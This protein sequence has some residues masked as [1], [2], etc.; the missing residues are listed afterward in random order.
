MNTKILVVDDEP[1][2]EML[3]RQGFRRKIQ[4]GAYQL[5]F[6]TNGR[7][8]VSAIEAE[9]DFDIVLLDINMPDMNGLTLLNLLPDLLPT[10]RAVMVSAYGDITNIRTAMN[11]GAFD[12]VFKPISFVDL[13]V[14]IEK[15]I[16]HV[17]ELRESAQLKVIDALKTRFF[18]NITHEFRTPLTLILSPV[19][20]MLREYA[21]SPLLRRNLESVERNARQLLRLVNQLLD[22]AKLEAGHLAVHAQPGDLKGLLEQIVLAFT[23]IAEQKELTLSYDTDLVDTYSFDAEK[24]GQISYNLIANA[25]KFTVQGGRV[26]VLLTV[27]DNPVRGVSL[28][29]KDSGIGIAPDKMPYIFNRFYQADPAT[30][31]TD[32]GTGIGLSLVRELTELMGGTVVVESEVGQGTTFIVELPL[33]IITDQTLTPTSKLPV[34]DWM[35][36][37]SFAA[38]L[39]LRQPVAADAALVLVVE[40]NTELREFLV[41]ELSSHY[42]VLS[43]D[44]GKTGWQLA[45]AELPDVVVSDVMMLGLDGYELTHELKTNPATDHIAVML[46][47]AKAAHESRMMGLQQG[48]DD[49]LAKPFHLE[50]LLLRIHNLTVR[51]QHL[52]EFY[53]QQLIRPDSAAQLETVQEKFLYSAY[54]IIDQHLDDST[55]GVEE[56]ASLLAMSRKTLLRKLQAVVQLSP[57][58]LI[59]QYRLQKAA[60]LL[61]AGY[62]VS[63]TAYQVGFENPSYFATAFKEFYQQTPTEFISKP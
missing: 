55:F 34:L 11:R 5:H 32:P 62:R 25:L 17:S 51:Q 57:N 4:E 47:T 40:D 46:L 23:P 38:E 39:P 48:A 6:V 35:P 18:D 58:D 12:F 15:T 9:P 30:Y 8:A 2:M 43:A 33:V 63:E 37:V 56:L 21:D 59:R 61:R 19:E 31:R 50:E 3:M 1:D 29:V 45:L 53:Q 60:E 26:N 24:V 54:A 28:R 52:R 13:E 22:L 10:G 49:Y 41:G 44:N 16:R 14:T 36:E 42:R 20:R 27:S 7:E